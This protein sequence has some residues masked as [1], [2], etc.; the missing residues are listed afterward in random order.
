MQM[1]ALVFGKIDEVSEARRSSGITCNRLI[2]PEHC[3]RTLARNKALKRAMFFR[4]NYVKR[5]VCHLTALDLSCQKTEINDATIR[6]DGS[7]TELERSD[8]GC[9]STVCGGSGE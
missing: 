6:R 5:S 8:G 1:S 3:L 9:L 4:R 7:K 2:C